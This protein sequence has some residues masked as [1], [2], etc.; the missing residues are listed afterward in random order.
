M[1]HIELMIQQWLIFCSKLIG[2][3]LLSLFTSF[4]GQGF[5]HFCIHA[6]QS[7]KHNLFTFFDILFHSHELVCNFIDAIKRWIIP[8]DI[9]NDNLVFLVCFSALFEILFAILSF[10]IGL[11]DV[12]FVFK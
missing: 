8:K 12:V 3:V 2:S 4:T 9:T 10:D 7:S 5:H 6:L 1:F 11:G